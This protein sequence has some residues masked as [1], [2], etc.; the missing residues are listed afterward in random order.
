MI[1]FSKIDLVHDDSDLVNAESNLRSRGR[2]VVRLS[3]ATGEGVKIL[4]GEM[5][6]ALDEAMAIADANEAESS[7]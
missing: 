1:V 5:L 4:L 7:A 3:A 2:T 6:Q